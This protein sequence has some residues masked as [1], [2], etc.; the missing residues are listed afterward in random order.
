LNRGGFRYDPATK[1]LSDIGRPNTG[2]SEFLFIFGGDQIAMELI[3]LIDC[4]EF[5][6][7]WFLQCDKNARALP[8]PLYS[9]MRLMAYAAN[10]SHDAELEKAALQKFRE[11]LTFE[12]GDHFPAKL[13]EIEGPS[14]PE[15]VKE[16]PGRNSFTPAIATPETA[17]W[18]L[19]MIT[20]PELLRLFTGPLINQA[21]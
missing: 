17:Q 19:D 3:S 9:Q 16:T 10:I 5:A 11:S 14:V 2:A 13:T 7:A 6:Q 20:T 15:P 8:G 18:A 4:P 1:H 21:V 12:G